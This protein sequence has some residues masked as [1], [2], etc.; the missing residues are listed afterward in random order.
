MPEQYNKSFTVLF[1][2]RDL[3]LVQRSDFGTVLRLRS[4]CWKRWPR[5]VIY[6]IHGNTNSCQCPLE[7]SLQMYLEIKSDSEAVTLIPSPHLT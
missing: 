2:S 6:T 7:F 4:R 3:T 1:P 5:T